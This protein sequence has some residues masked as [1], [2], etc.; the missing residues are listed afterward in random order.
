MMPNPK[1]KAEKPKLILHPNLRLFSPHSGQFCKKT[2]TGN[3]ICIAKNII[4]SCF[5]QS[6]SVKIPFEVFMFCE[7]CIMMLKSNFVY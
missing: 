6:I 1:E 5:T 4:L 3:I 2:K 7:C